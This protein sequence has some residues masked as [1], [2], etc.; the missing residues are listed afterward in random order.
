MKRMID[1]LKVLRIVVDR[2][3]CDDGMRILRIRLL[4]LYTM[5]LTGC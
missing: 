3:G 4:V 5:G 2:G 1:L